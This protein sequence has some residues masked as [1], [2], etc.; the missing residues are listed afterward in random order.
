MQT[1]INPLPEEYASLLSRPLSSENKEITTRVEAIIE[2][3]RT[4]G[5]TA[6]RELSSE[7]DRVELVQIRVSEQEIARAESSLSEE[8]K[9][10]IRTAQRNIT[11]FHSAQKMSPI[12]I[13]VTPGIVCSQRSVPIARVGLYVP[14][15][16]APLF[17][18]VLMLAT[19]AVIAGCREIVLCTPPQ[20]TGEVAPAVLWTAA[21]CGVTHIYKVGGAQAIAAMA[22]GTE[23]VPKVDKIFGPGNRYVTTAKQLL[24][25]SA[26]AIDMPA[27][28]S[29]VMV[30]ADESARASFVASDLLSQA[31]HG[32]DSQAIMVTTSTKLAHQ[33]EV[34]IDRQLQILSR[35]D[36]ATKALKESRIIVVKTLDQMI[37]IANE[38]AAEH[39]ILA[40]ENPQAVADRIENAGSIFL[41]HWSPESVGDYASGTNH[42]LP[43]SGWATAFSGV[44]LDS[45]CR[46]I[47][48]QSL[49][50]LGLRAIGPTT[51][52][53]AAAE[54][55]DAHRMAVTIRLQEIEKQ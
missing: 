9:D 22:Y 8:L 42:T 54:G 3:V 50:P 34:E 2:R 38:Y 4:G 13:E 24:G 18:T 36:T 37:T 16:S 17:S 44:N 55:L 30:V 49:T 5:D 48:Y 20:A 26:V 15:G 51:E 32:A 40:V 33:V 6:L 53:M 47:T 12:E 46:K 10:A 35:R 23:S 39:L 31:E 28:P 19:P 14:G 25:L 43:T 11:A 45:F 52:V 27:G 21:L 41:G 7:I 29:E 1:Y